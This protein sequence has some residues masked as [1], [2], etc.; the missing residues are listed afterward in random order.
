[1][2]HSP[3]AMPSRSPAAV[4]SHSPVAAAANRSPGS[5]AVSHSPSAGA[6]HTPV[7]TVCGSPAGLSGRSK[8]GSSPRPGVAPASSGG[9]AG[10]RRDDKPGAAGTGRELSRSSV[11]KG[12]VFCP[13]SPMVESTNDMLRAAR[14][15]GVVRA[16]T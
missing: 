16:R 11:L 2:S 6:G 12:P 14:G 9:A 13:Q 10:R 8:W 5:A 7:A 4:L 15:G 3:T 1:M